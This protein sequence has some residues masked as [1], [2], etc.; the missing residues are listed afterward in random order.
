[1]GGVYPRDVQAMT[2][3][4]VTPEAVVLDLPTASPGSRAL[5][6]LLDVA[7]HPGPVLRALVV[8]VIAA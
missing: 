6:R 2:N 4:V 5:A 3:G 7:G 8:L 1:M